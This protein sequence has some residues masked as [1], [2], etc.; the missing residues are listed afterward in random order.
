[1]LSVT[2]EV[3]YCMYIYQTGELF[4]G[5]ENKMNITLN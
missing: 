3:G 5:Y 4:S 2:N 1:M